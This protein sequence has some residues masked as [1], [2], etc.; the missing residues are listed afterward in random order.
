M[1]VFFIHLFLKT[2]DVS[3]KKTAVNIYVIDILQADLK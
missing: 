1:C 3:T 2:I